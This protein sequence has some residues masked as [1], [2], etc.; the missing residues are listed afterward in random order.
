[1][2]R[3]VLAIAAGVALSFF[4]FRVPTGEPLSTTKEKITVVPGFPKVPPEAL[5]V[6]GAY[7]IHEIMPHTVYKITDDL[8]NGWYRARARTL[9]A[10][11]TDVVVLNVY[12]NIMFYPAD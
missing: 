8:G 1:M 6:G 10:D 4:L 2:K 5:Q 11:A 12:S 3:T 7:E 9:Y